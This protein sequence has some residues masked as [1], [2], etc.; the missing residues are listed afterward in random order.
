MNVARR[1]QYSV[2]QGLIRDLERALEESGTEEWKLLSTLDNLL[3]AIEEEDLAQTGDESDSADLEGQP[4]PAP[5]SHG[6]HEGRE[7]LQLPG[8]GGLAADVPRGTLQRNSESV[9]LVGAVAGLTDAQLN[10][11]LRR[12]GVATMKAVRRG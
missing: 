12:R 4:A 9:P 2:L 1:A 5:D 6:P 10:A 7:Q 3:F 8:V 11:E